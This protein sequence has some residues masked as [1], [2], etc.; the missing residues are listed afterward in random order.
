MDKTYGLQSLEAIFNYWSK[1]AFVYSSDV[2]ESKQIKLSPELIPTP[3]AK[4]WEMNTWLKH[5]RCQNLA[6]PEKQESPKWKI[7]ESFEMK[8]NSVHY[9]LLFEEGAFSLGSGALTVHFEWLFFLNKNSQ[10][11]DVFN[12]AAWTEIFNLLKLDVQK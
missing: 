12:K 2:S 11:C 3:F 8:I 1:K 6:L 5:W 7:L 4:Q 9:I 10:V